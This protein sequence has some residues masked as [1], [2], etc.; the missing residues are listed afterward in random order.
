MRQ[1]LYLHACV[2]VLLITF[3]ISHCSR[4][5]AATYTGKLVDDEGQ[6]IAGAVVVG[7]WLED[8]GEL[9]GRSDRL[10]DVK[11]T[12]TDSNGAWSIEGPSGVKSDSTLVHILNVMY[13]LFSDAKFRKKVVELCRSADLWVSIR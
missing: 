13:K 2:F 3:L 9:V 8:R 10:K 11:E 5:Y 12:L 6:P 7:Y 4:G 1:V